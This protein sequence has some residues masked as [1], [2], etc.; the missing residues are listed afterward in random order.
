MV[1]FPASD[2]RLAREDKFTAPFNPP[3]EN[4]HHYHHTVFNL[5]AD[6]FAAIEITRN[7]I[8]KMSGKNLTLK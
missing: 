3:N 5:F 1:A 2:L 8:P 4:P 7:V 6:S